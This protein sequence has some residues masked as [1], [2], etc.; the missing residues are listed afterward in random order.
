MNDEKEIETPV[1]VPIPKNFAADG[2]FLGYE[3]KPL[4]IIQAIILGLI[5]FFVVFGFLNKIFIFNNYISLLAITGLCSL[6]F[7]YLGFAGI[8]NVTPL[9]YLLRFLNFKKKERKAYYN[10]RVKKEMIS[11]SQERNNEASKT[12]PRDK[13]MKI[14]NEFLTKRNL[15]DQQK[16]HEIEDN[17]LGEEV[18]FEEDFLVMTKPKEY[19]TEKELKQQEKIEKKEMKKYQKSLKKKERDERKNAKTKAKKER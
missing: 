11:L 9:E 5:P 6:A 4:N 2:T 3:L 15:S 10:P 8:D 17:D 18:Y 14:Y 7:A 16:A 19:M 12:L 13:V 1:T